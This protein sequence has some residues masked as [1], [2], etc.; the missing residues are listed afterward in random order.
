MWKS[1]KK[2][3]TEDRTA[4]LVAAAFVVLV[5]WW[6]VLQLIGSAA[7]SE[8][9]NLVWAASYQIVAI[10][11]GVFGIAISRSWGGFKSVMGR[12][13]VF[14]SLGLLFQAFG[15][16]AFS[17]YN[18]ALKVDV[19]YPSVA[20]IGF[21]GSVPFYIVG[22]LL[23]ARA[24][25]VNIS[26]RSFASQLQAIVIPLIV[27][28]ASY[29]LFLRGYK[30]EESA[31]LKVLL[32]FGY[33]LGQAVYVSIALL[34]YILSRS[35]LG[36]VMRDRVLFILVALVVQYFADFNFLFQALNE[37]WQNGGYGDLIYLLAYLFMT[38]GLLRLQ[39]RYIQA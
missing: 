8:R 16:T 25:G 7:I 4:Q 34:T 23:L 9:R 2:V 17:F 5:V 18:L 27:V 35:I 10:F 15:Q 20:D 31:P 33:P 11:G 39:V 24:S 32:D 3:I 13:I 30:F 19:P 36:G 14:F 28:S 38:L 12:A 26:L 29:A 22:I 37:T 1:P 6:F 21:F